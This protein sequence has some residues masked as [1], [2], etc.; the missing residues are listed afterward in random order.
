MGGNLGGWAGA[1]RAV[2]RLPT[3]DER[4]SWVG[5]PADVAGWGFIAGG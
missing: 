2:A 3:H 5:H 1:G 4:M